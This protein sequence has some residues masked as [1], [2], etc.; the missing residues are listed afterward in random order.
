MKLMKEVF[1]RV[2]EALRSLWVRVRVRLLTMGSLIVFLGICLFI[3][4]RMVYSESHEQL[5]RTLESFAEKFSQTLEMLD[6]D[7]KNLDT[8]EHARLRSLF[9]DPMYGDTGYPF[10]V[11]MT[12]KIDFHFF[13]DGDRLSREVMDQMASAP[14]RRGSLRINFDGGQTQEREIIF[15]YVRELDCFLAIE[16]S[17]AVFDAT[18]NG[19]RIYS[20][21]LFIFGSLL[22]WLMLSYYTHRETRFLKSLRSDLSALAEG[23]LPE[24][25]AF[26][27]QKEVTQIVDALKRL[28]DGLSNTTAFVK[29]LAINDLTQ[30]YTPM[31]VR[32]ELGNSLLELRSAL[33]KQEIEAGH[34]KEEERIRSW[35]NEGLAEFAK[36]LRENSNDIAL[37]ADVILKR[38]VNYLEAMQGALYMAE[39]RK[40]GTVLH[41]VSAFAYNRKKFLKQDLKLGEG[42][43]G[44]CAIER[45]LVHIDVLPPEYCEIT[46]GI[47]NVP[48]KELL[49]VPLKTDD[50]LLGVLE[51]ASLKGFAPYMVAFAQLL[52]V[53]IAQTLQQVQTNQRTA[54]LL[55]QSQE[56]R[57][58]MRSQEE[59]MRQNL[60][61]MQATQEEMTRRTQEY[62][63]LSYVLEQATF[64][65]EFSEEGLLLQSNQKLKEFLHQLGFA[66]QTELRILDLVEVENSVTEQH[67]ETLTS[68]WK[69]ILAGVSQTF[70]L[71]FRT[72]KPALLYAAFTSLARDGGSRVYMLAQDIANLFPNGEKQPTKPEE[73]R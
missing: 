49:L 13:R 37:L 69:N 58:A 27:G 31:G 36:L 1:L 70:V 5:S 8:V 59:E 2:V 67:A 50:A 15:T 44:T 38:I 52:S 60:E 3:F 7:L 4:E 39:E 55:K 24:Q 25:V 66:E 62:E 16:V 40:T 41:L 26:R 72:E 18:L 53:S 19:I 65:A 11:Q 47:G 51:L 29:H 35:S 42:L 34:I 10:V 48:P 21:A 12:G 30:E 32:D 57:E 17:D 68:S 64:Y 14:S 54:E 20:W 73:Y 6:L 63:V 45:E 23:I 46:S 28:I 22:V 33:Q 43:V 9:R 71:R 56:Q 61:E